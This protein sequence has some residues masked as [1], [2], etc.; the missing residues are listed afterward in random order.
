MARARSGVCLG[1]TV[2]ENYKGYAAAARA[3]LFWDA[4]KREKSEE[5]LKEKKKKEKKEKS[6]F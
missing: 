1:I 4:E 3:T 5:T 6:S 2:A